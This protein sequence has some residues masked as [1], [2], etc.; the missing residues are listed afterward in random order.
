[1][2]TTAQRVTSWLIVASVSILGALCVIRI[3]GYF[4]VDRQLDL[5]AETVE[6]SDVAGRERALAEQASRLA[7]EPGR[8]RAALAK[9]LEDLN[10]FQSQLKKSSLLDAGTKQKVK[11]LDL[12]LSHITVSG[13]TIVNSQDP[14]NEEAAKDE[15]KFHQQLFDKTMSEVVETLKDQ[16]YKR[17]D[18]NGSTSW[19]TLVIGLGFTTLAIIIVA[20]P[21]R[22]RLSTTL[23]QLELAHLNAEDRAEELHALQIELERA[24]AELKDRHI[25]LRSAYDESTSTNQFL[26][27]SSAR[28]EDLFHGVP[29]ACFSVDDDGHVYEWNEAAS[30][31][32]GVPG[33]QAIQRSIFGKYFSLDNDF[34][35]KGLIAEAFKGNHLRNIEVE[36]NCL[37]G[38]RQLLVSVFPL[39]AARKEPTAAL[40]AC[41]DITR[42]K[43]AELEAHRA[44]DRVAAILR[45]IKDAFVTIDRD[46]VYCY[47]NNA[48]AEWMGLDVS[49]IIGKHV[50][51]VS[52]SLKDTG[53]VERIE[54]VMASGAADT[55]ERYDES[56]GV[57]F[58]FRAYPSEEGASVFYNDITERKR[59]N[60]TILKQQEQLETAMLRLSESSVQLEQNRM[61]LEE[62]NRHL[63][64]LA[65]TDGLTGLLNHRAMQDELI[66]ATNKSATW[67]VPVSVALL[68]V[69]HFKKFN[70]AFGHQAGDQVLMQMALHLRA[71]VRDG[72][73][74]ARYGG[75][76]F[77]VIFPDTQ[78]DEAAVVCE[79]IRK[80]VE[81]SDWEHRQV[82]VSIGFSTGVGVK[83]QQE[84]IRQA[85]QALYQ[86][87]A[88]GRNCVVPFKG[89]STRCA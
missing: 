13:H 28:F 40:I 79:R 55:F 5:T 22:G 84:L 58:E 50:T 67:G 29:F 7:W 73:I 37:D 48:A 78:A 59:A 87:K 74:V 60:D 56:R 21:L 89:E 63:Q 38:K 71:A 70:D 57:W 69:D 15:I 31:M 85:D 77:C 68:D 47:V 88:A 17:L 23:Q 65:V 8:D 24:N 1:M 46:Q 44:N 42:Q 30:Q 52:P 35:L 49:E 19:L 72:D 27:L 34:L 41:A 18:D 2:K 61:D 26:Q 66:I 86:A 83:D 4:V 16:S 82:T 45:S 51:E 81:S 12:S 3:A 20:G 64:E 80:Q 76:E 11:S 9:T 6:L 33:H 39:R 32:F 62:A 36:A 43:E 53:F 25:K 10:D 14:D 54:A 75:E